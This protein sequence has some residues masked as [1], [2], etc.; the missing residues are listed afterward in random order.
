[1]PF[2]EYTETA[3]AEMYLE[4]NPG[5]SKSKAQ[6]EA[7][8]EYRRRRSEAAPHLILDIHDLKDPTCGEAEYNLR[9][10]A[11]AQAAARRAGA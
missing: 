5:A 4:A 8:K 9:R 10:A 1:M 11:N 7:K 6:R 2:Y 3:L